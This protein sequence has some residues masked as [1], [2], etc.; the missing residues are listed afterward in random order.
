[1]PEGLQDGRDR[2]KQKR[3]DEGELQKQIDS[4]RQCKL[5]TKALA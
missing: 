3:D 1:M 2:V 4:K 5:D